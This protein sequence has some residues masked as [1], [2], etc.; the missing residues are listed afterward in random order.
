MLD[1]RRNRLN[2]GEIISPPAGYELT[3]AV[4]TTYSL[5]LY[6][7]LA[8]PVAMFYAN[9]L[10]GDFTINRYDVLEAIRQSKDRIDLFCQKGKIK[11]QKEYNN[12]L[13][14]MEDCVEEI[15]TPIKDS[16]FH[17]K[18]WVLR[19]ENKE[20]VIYRLVVLSRNLTFDRSWD[21]A[22]YSEGKVGKVENA[23]SKKLVAYLKS[24]Y[25]QT[26]RKGEPSFFIDLSKVNFTVPIGFSELEILPIQHFIKSDLLN[27]LKERIHSEMLLISPFVHISTLIDLQK[28]NKRLTVISRKEELDKLDHK[29]LKNIQ[30]YFINPIA[31][32]GERIID[33]EGEEPLS[34]NLHA[35]VFIA[36]NGEFTDWYIGSAN[37]TEPAFGRNVECMVKIRTENK[38]L[39]LKRVK[40]QLLDEQ[41]NL[42]M[43]YT[44]PE[45]IPVDQEKETQE[46]I[47]ELVFELNKLELKGTIEQADNENFDLT[48]WV[49]LTKMNK[50]GLDIKT[51]LLH[52]QGERESLTVSSINKVTFKNIALTNLS[53]YVIL[54]IWSASDLVY[55]SIYKLKIEI[56]ES[57]EDVIFNRLINNRT[58]FLQYLQF[59]LQPERTIG[60]REIKNMAT[61]GDGSG[62]ILSELFGSGSSI[63]ESLML[64]A[65]RSPIKLKQIDSIIERLKKADSEVV[66]DFLPIWEVYK[67]FIPD[68]RA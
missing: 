30:F 32:E 64:T 62:N 11:V 22:F 36:N 52:R 57:R 17:P 27:P 61:R 43:P 5:D 56:P 4:G 15:E 23:E 8:M 44:P 25:E 45:E 40:K 58:K 3:K 29:Q 48:C 34:Q 2:Y 39:S 54:E 18:I 19:F 51:R 46:K 63:Y 1:V 47:R 10:D 41:N 33:S 9:S 55:S 49:D 59:I 20:D 37:A 26:K 21:I 67:T 38:S 68:G 66:E 6:A 35:K 31:V 7:L 28:V 16:S 53:K 65:S 12:L 50:C 42:F 60:S 13:A 14:F 24:F